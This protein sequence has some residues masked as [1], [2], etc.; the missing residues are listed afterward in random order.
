MAPAQ[1]EREIMVDAPLERV[2]AVL[3][4]PAHIAGWFGDRAEVYPRPGGAAAF[5]WDSDGTFLATVD[6]V[7][8]PTF[9]SYRW[10]HK[11]DEQPREGNSTLVELTL[12]P[13]GNGTRLSVVETGFDTLDVP[14]AERI[15]NA[16]L[17]TLGWLEELD[18][19]REYA[20]R[21]AD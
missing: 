14:E 21:L 10:A 2:W 5:H 19:M 6:R 18:E 12:S 13:E 15:R 4:E 8:P 16:E 17:N 11:A 1:I 9:F 7:E 20:Q 3:T